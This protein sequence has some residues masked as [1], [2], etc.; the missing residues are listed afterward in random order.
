MSAGEAGSAP[1]L[2]GI[3]VRV[4]PARIDE[5]VA[6]LPRLAGVE[7][8]H[9]DAAAG[10]IVVVDESPS[11]QAAQDALRTIQQLPFVQL[12]ELVY[13]LVDAP[14]AGGASEASGCGPVERP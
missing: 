8:H 13:H 7:V 9:C 2:S 11:R 4:A 12:A 1:H 6:A 5:A 10:K 14:P 3:L